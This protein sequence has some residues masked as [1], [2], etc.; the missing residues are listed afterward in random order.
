MSRKGQKILH[1]LCFSV[2]CEKERKAQKILHALSICISQC[3][4]GVMMIPGSILGGAIVVNMH[5]RLSNCK[6]L[7]LPKNEKPGEA[8]N[9][10]TLVIHIIWDSQLLIVAQ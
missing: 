10:R 5:F 6:F 1:I 2:Q 7:L 4:I 3:C 8:S 9:G